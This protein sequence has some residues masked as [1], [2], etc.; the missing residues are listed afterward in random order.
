MSNAKPV[1]IFVPGLGATGEVYEPFLK[2]WRK[3][4]DVRIAMHSLDLPA[5]LDLPFFFRAIEA[6]AQGD[7]FTLVGHSMG[8][9]IT[10]AYSAAHP[11][12]VIKTVAI[13][14]VVVSKRE[15]FPKGM[16]RFRWFR[17][18]QNLW[19][20]LLAGNPL[21]SL[22]TVRIRAHVLANGRRR[23]LYDWI[24]TVDLS[25]QLD[26]L[27]NTTVLWAKHE[28]VL[29]QD[30]LVELEKHPNLNLKIIPGSHNHLPLHPRPIQKYVEE[31]IN[32]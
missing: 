19:L 15:R 30:H 27:K 7:R 21:H 26:S 3:Q 12:R 16:V 10:L 17:R 28:E 4:Y 32:G 11:G 31:A 6:A 13:A 14:P 20:G 22:K 8:G 5:R 2:P 9:M 25:D 24:N 18:L 29:T 1:M 23:A